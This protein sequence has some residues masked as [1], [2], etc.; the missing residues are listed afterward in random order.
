MKHRSWLVV[1]ALAFSACE[2]GDGPTEDDGPT[3][4][5]DHTGETESPTTH[6]GKP[7]DLPKVYVNEV[8]AQNATGLQDELGAFP[9]WIE[10]YNPGD[11][12]VDLEG[13]WL[14]DDTE[15]KFKWQFPAGNF[16]PPQGYL[17]IYADGDVDEGPHHAGFKISGLSNEDIA[18]FGPNVDDNPQ[19]DALE[20]MGVQVP[21]VSLAR[22]PD[23][24]PTWE[25]DET[26]TPAAANN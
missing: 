26:P 8:M 17:V 25:Q 24:G 21:D 10:L 12:E 15:D 1:V 18:L 2:G 22:M 6:T 7:S 14:S 3:D 23:G 5:V 20:D 13:W 16:V 11:A 4:V 9:D 19:V